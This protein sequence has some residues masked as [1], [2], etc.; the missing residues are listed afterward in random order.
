MLRCINSSNVS[1]PC[2]TFSFGHMEAE[3]YDYTFLANS[4]NVKPYIFSSILVSI[5]DSCTTEWIKEN[6]G[7]IK[8][9]ILAKVMDLWICIKSINFQS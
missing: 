1:D 4:M 8:G 7:C 3:V 5:N 2:L 6:D 9:L